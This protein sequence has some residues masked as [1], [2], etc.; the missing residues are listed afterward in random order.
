MAEVLVEFDAAFLGADGATYTPRACARLNEDGLWEG[1]LE[2]TD[3][4]T[5]VVIRSGRETTQP[6]RAD[7]MYWATGLT[8][9]YLEGALARTLGPAP[10]LRPARVPSEPAYDAPAPRP[11]T[12]E[13][14]GPRAVLD[15]F[16]VYAQGEKVLRQELS[17]LDLDHLR[18]IV[19]AYGL[20]GGAG[21]D[22]P[23]AN[24]VIEY[25]IAEVRA[26]LGVAGA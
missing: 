12:V 24:V 9:V 20:E 11:G 8:R 5:A 6:T 15:P 22:S 19:Q 14:V 3:V 10:R 2:F 23:L 21:A 4:E 25:I 7:V 17:A 1:W 18:A 26:A 16:E 13:M